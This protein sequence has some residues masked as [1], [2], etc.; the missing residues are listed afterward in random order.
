M[1]EHICWLKMMG[2]VCSLSALKALALH[3][4]EILVYVQPSRAQ[5][6]GSGI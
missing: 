2:R 6:L 1:V 4:I 3:A 5:H